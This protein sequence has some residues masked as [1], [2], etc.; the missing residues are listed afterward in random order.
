MNTYAI[1][2]VLAI[3][4]SAY[5]NISVADE[6]NIQQIKLNTIS[7]LLDSS[8]VSK[9]ILNSGND[10]AIQYYNLSKTAYKSAVKEFENGN[11]EKSNI[12]IKKSTDAL[13]D[14]TLF[15]NINKADVNM[16]A[17]RHLFEETKK[18]VDALM[19]A[20]YRVSEE[21]GKNSQNQKAI[22]EINKLN[23]HANELASRKLY[24]QALKELENTLAMIRN[25]IS[26]LK[27]GDTL[28]R[29]LS[30]ANKQEEYNYEV[31]RNNA[32][33]MLL[34]MFLTTDAEKKKFETYKESAQ[35]LRKQAENSA[36]DADYNTA[37]QTLEKSTRIIINTIRQ[38]GTDIP[39]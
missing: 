27:M 11:I 7:K 8:S 21:K 28:V 10:V 5:V 12:F 36:K 22:D 29:S 26:E 2:I 37:I 14:A 15:A 3:L 20:V 39:S 38:A 17:D 16:D 35:K 9:H 23:D 18:S 6:K 31:D 33:F 4:I 34:K 13:S 32:H 25:N 19:L 30:F 24:T 1:P